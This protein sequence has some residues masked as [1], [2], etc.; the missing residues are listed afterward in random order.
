[1]RSSDSVYLLVCSYV[2]F[3][4]FVETA[5]CVKFFCCLLANHSSFLPKIKA[6]ST[7]TMPQCLD[8]A[9]SDFSLHHRCQSEG[10]CIVLQ[11]LI[12]LSA[13]LYLHCVTITIKDWDDTYDCQP[14]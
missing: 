10:R 13:R 4:I 12:T 5:G 9:V 3:V 1:M 8:F 7:I 2:T 11:L 14:P 6:L